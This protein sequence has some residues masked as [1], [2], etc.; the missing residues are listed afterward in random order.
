M[1][2]RIAIFIDEIK[3]NLISYKLISFQVLKK[4][5][6]CMEEYYVENVKSV[7]NQLDISYG[8]K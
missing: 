4:F 3:T 8:G 2:E 1:N 7:P 6:L 5:M